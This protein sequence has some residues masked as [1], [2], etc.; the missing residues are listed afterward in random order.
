MQQTRLACAMAFALVGAAALV[1]AKPATPVG[2]PST[3]LERSTT[4]PANPPESLIEFVCSILPAPH[5][6]DAD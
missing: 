2:P 1:E 4:P 6:C 5:L 3:P